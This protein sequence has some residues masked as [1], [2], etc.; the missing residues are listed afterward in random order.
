MPSD[1]LTQTARLLPLIV[2]ATHAVEAI[3]T[4]AR[5]RDKQEAAVDAVH[6]ALAAAELGL[7][8]DL[9]NDE[10]VDD[11][12]RGVIDAYV[13]LQNA[14]AAHQADEAPPPT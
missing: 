7:G 5:G 9:L 2:V 10:D 4:V 1:W 12:V 6:A 13:A 11:A 14:V 8:R 3:A